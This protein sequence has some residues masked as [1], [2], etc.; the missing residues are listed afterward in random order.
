MTVFPFILRGV[1]LC[2]IDSAG[3][4][5]DARSLIWNKITTDWRIDD[6]TSIEN[7]SSLEDL[8]DDIDRILAG[9]VF[10]RVIVKTKG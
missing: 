8:P 4:S 6:L 7:E 10:G 3:I 1:T 2:G 5:R 9:K